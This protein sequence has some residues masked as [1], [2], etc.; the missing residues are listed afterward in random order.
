VKTLT[1]E[2]VQKAGVFAW[3]FFEVGDKD[4][5]SGFLFSAG[6]LLWC[7]DEFGDFIECNPEDLAEH[8]DLTRMW[9]HLSGC[10]CEFCI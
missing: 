8:N 4:V 1:L 5:F 10:D 3:E 9:H 6:R 2:Q 7:S